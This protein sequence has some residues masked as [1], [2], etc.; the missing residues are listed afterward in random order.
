MYEGVGLRCTIVAY[1]VH[2]RWEGK[3]TR[4]ITANLRQFWSTQGTP[5]HLG[6]GRD[7]QFSQNKPRQMTH[8]QSVLPLVKFRHLRHFSLYVLLPSIYSVK[9]WPHAQCFNP[10]WLSS[11]HAPTVSR[12]VGPV[13]VGSFTLLSRPASAHCLAWPHPAFVVLGILL[14]ALCILDR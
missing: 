7:S 2:L 12:N 8:L 3:N 6:Y 11:S 13:F 5:G 10:C 1:T 14:W 4:R 9:R